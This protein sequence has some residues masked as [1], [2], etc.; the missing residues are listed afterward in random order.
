MA[1]EHNNKRPTAASMLN[2]AAFCT[3]LFAVGGLSI[4]MEKPTYSEQEKRD[5]AKMPELTLKGYWDGSLASGIDAFYSD[6][7]PFRDALISLG[8]TLEEMRGLRLDDAKIH[9]TAPS[10]SEP[11][12]PTEPG[13][14]RR[15]RELFVQQGRGNCCGRTERFGIHL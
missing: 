11:E 12:V 7:F 5:L 1:N 4:A 9:E 3:A 6:T 2:I 14:R 10:T 8:S 15:N 13:Q